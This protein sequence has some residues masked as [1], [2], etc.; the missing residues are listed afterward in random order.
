MALKRNESQL[1]R[2][3]YWLEYM[4][5]SWNVI[6]VVVLGI[7]AWSAKSV[8]LAGFGLDSLVEIVAS[9]VVVWELGKVNEQRQRRALGLIG[10]A[11]IV[12]A[13][14]IFLQSLIVLITGYHPRHSVPGIA[15]TALTCVVMLGLAFGKAS[16]GKA[17]GNPVLATEGRV[18][19]IDA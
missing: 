5:L 4:T 10:V 12:L 16:T 2:R 9:V 15:W 8:A 13:I 14:Y 18:T 1:L 19:L 17:L 6:G 7:A 3:G 11:F